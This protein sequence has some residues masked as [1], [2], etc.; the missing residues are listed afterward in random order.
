MADIVQKSTAKLFVEPTTLRC[1]WI[2]QNKESRYTAKPNTRKPFCIHFYT[3]TTE[4]V[5]H[6][7][8]QTGRRP[9][10]SQLVLLACGWCPPLESLPRMTQSG[11]VETVLLLL[12]GK[13]TVGRTRLIKYTRVSRTSVC[14][15]GGGRFDISGAF[16]SGT[17]NRWRWKMRLLRCG[18]VAL[19]Q[20]S[21]LLS[22]SI[23]LSPWPSPSF[24]IGS[25][26]LLVC[27]SFLAHL[28]A[29]LP[30]PH[31]SQG[32]SC[33]YLSSLPPLAPSTS[34]SRLVE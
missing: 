5:V 18:P 6:N 7:D 10:L 3:S 16:N 11:W 22:L 12:G 1:T 14:V 19:S 17:G 15:C 23:S 2:T 4:T 30:L 21:P 33:R 20:E 29:L 9:H 32:T 26:V 31:N 27:I 25:L 8:L 13:M 34:V 28:L 24:L